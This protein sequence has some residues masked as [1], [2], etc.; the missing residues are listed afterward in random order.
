MKHWMKLKFP[1]ILEVV[2]KPGESSGS[3]QRI[4]VGS[5]ISEV[6]SEIHFPQI[7]DE[8][9]SLTGFIPH[10]DAITG[11]CVAGYIG[12]ERCLHIARGAA[13]NLAGDADVE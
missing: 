3:H 12:H 13:R 2:S 6:P 5:Q 4:V 9:V 11:V 7:H 10:P 1:R 8:R